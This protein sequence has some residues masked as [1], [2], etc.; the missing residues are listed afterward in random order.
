M[1]RKGLGHSKPATLPHYY[2]HQHI[3]WRFQLYPSSPSC[4]RC[5]MVHTWLL[6]FFKIQMGSKVETV[7]THRLKPCHAPQD[8][9]AT[10][11]PRRGCLPNA[12]KSSVVRQPPLH[13]AM[14]PS[15]SKHRRRVSF[16]CPVVTS[17]SPPQ[18]PQRPPPAPSDITLG[19]PVCSIAR[20]ARYT[21]YNQH[22]EL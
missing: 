11:P 1:L 9:Q 10:A 18:P 4:R 17:G 12:I 7:S 6:Y 19:R 5:M 2:A 14:S 13:S 8:A 16:A 21:A 22:T 3:L 20:P 15:N